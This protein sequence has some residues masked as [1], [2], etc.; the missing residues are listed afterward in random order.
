[1]ATFWRW[2]PSFYFLAFILMNIL[3]VVKGQ[4][5]YD[6]RL[7]GGS[8]D[9]EG[10][11]EIYYSGSWGTICDDG[12]GS[13]EAD[14][15]CR[16]LGYDY[17]LAYHYNA[18]FGEGS[19]NIVLDDV[20]CWGYESQ[21]LEC[22]SAGVGN[23]NCGHHE[24]VG[25]ECY[26]QSPT[27]D[28][29]APPANSLRLVNGSTPY[30]GRLEI[31]HNGE[32][33][34]ICH[35]SFDPDDADVACRQLGYGGLQRAYYNA[36]FGEGSGRVWIAN[37]ICRG[38]EAK[39]VHCDLYWEPSLYVCP[40]SEDVG[41]RCTD[42]DAT[43]RLIGGDTS[44]EGRV[45]ILH[46][47]EWGT[48]CDDSWGRD[49]AD[50][51]CQQLNFSG[52]SEAPGNAYFGEGTGSIW[53]DDVSCFGGESRIEDCHHAG[54][55]NENCGHHEDASVI[56]YDGED[57]GRNGGLNAAEI[58]GI[59]VGSIVGFCVLVC[60][61]ATSC[62]DSQSRP[63]TNQPIN[64]IAPITYHNPSTLHAEP[65]ER[66][67]PPPPSYDQRD[68]YSAYPDH[69]N[70]P[71]P[72]PQQAFD[73]VGG[74]VTGGSYPPPPQQG[75]GYYP[76]SGQSLEP[77]GPIP[78]SAGVEEHRADAPHPRSH[79]PAWPS[80][81]I[82]AH[83]SSYPPPG[84]QGGTT[85]S[86]HASISNPAPPLLTQPAPVPQAYVMYIPPHQQDNNYPSTL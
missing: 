37:L 6:L 35:D 11:V 5:W 28:P 31:Y 49:E 66:S 16:Q 54:W 44:S 1:M 68:K 26:P 18:Y 30:D 81:P 63:P 73:P 17:A 59:A 10:R 46:D 9:S 82:G 86:G 38:Y 61:I 47:G 64:N 72:P 43:L 70:A 69:H 23:N 80:S 3:L 48:I 15:A 58:A 79:Y 50:V 34:T 57:D 75:P 83:P 40:H 60:V 53:L 45:E 67:A 27:P 25:V 20:S 4:N 42:P 78:Y 84:I 74:H 7:V 19:G 71:P 21:L 12:W 22:W 41:V 62:K 2:K 56:C 13:D 29:L 55:G 65:S 8:R 52:A 77:P 76:S 24:D 39:L 85:G 51:V 33:G 32:W 36:E 14:V